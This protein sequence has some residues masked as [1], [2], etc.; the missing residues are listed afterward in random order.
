MPPKALLKSWKY[1]KQL[2]PAYR[3]R[4]LVAFT[5]IAAISLQRPSD[6]PHAA[7]GVRGNQMPAC[8][9]LRYRSRR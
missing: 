4:Y 1:C 5:A 3:I 7:W 9:A 8:R 6:N 2:R